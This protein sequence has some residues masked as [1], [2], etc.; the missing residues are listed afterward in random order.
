MEA[1]VLLHY[2]QQAPE[3]AK[4]LWLDIWKAKKEISFQL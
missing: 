2:K 4:V 1:D 3:F